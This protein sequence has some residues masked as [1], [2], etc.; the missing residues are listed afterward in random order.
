M[1]IVVGFSHHVILRD[2]YPIEYFITRRIVYNGTS[3]DQPWMS[4]KPPIPVIL[5]TYSCP[6]NVIAVRVVLNTGSDSADRWF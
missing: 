5:L 1:I 4:D 6:S 2:H 3:I